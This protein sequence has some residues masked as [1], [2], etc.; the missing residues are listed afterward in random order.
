MQIHELA[1]L[2][3]TPTTGD[4]LAIDTGSATVKIDYAALATAI[5]NK[6]GAGSDGVVDIAHGGTGESTAVEARA[7]LGAAASAE[8]ADAYDDNGTYDVG[9]LCIYGNTLYVCI[10]PITTAEAWT[11]DHWMATT[12]TAELKGKLGPGDVVNNL[13]SSATDKPLA[14]AQGKAL[15]D[16]LAKTSGSVTPNTTYIINNALNWSKCGNVV[17]IHGFFQSTS[18]GAPADS[19]LYTLPF[20]PI[21]NGGCAIATY[22]GDEIRALV[23]N[24]NNKALKLQ[25]SAMS[26]AKWFYCAFAYIASD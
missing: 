7:A 5:L 13:D 2:G 8:L 15:N 24:A 26:A 12:V 23:W 22:D 6:L 9:D 1:A 10:T 21:S 18:Q 14:A 25:T 16:M 11:P 17:C 3:R 19:Q 20:T 4:S